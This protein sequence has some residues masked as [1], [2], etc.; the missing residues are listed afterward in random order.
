MSSISVKVSGRS[1]CF[2]RIFME[3]TPFSTFLR[4]FGRI[5]SVR[6]FSENEPFPRNV[7]L[8]GM[9]AFFS[10][11]PWNAEIPM[12]VSMSGRAIVSR[13]LYSNAFSPICVTVPG[14]I[15]SVMPFGD[16]TLSLSCVISSSGILNALSPIL[17]I[18]SFVSGLRSGI[19]S[20]L[21]SSL[22]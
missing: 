5:I 17:V 22:V 7:T 9:T 12:A 3:N 18:A 20:L 6:L 15:T 1:I 19:F 8:S 2:R 21:F 16:S 14:M 13:L 10:L 4:P 11:L